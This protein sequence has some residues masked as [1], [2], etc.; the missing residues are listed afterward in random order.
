MTAKTIRGAFLGLV[1][2]LAASWV[3]KFVYNTGGLP[4][5]SLPGQR[6]S[7]EDVQ[8]K[9]E[10]TLRSSLQSKIGKDVHVANYTLVHKVG[11]EYTGFATI[12]TADSADGVQQV[13]VDV[14]VDDDGRYL[15]RWED[16]P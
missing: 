6:P 7:A 9:S 11:G 4:Q 12:S 14:T 10:D 3:Y 8:L 2:A 1:A 15:V 13:S 5:L 16:V